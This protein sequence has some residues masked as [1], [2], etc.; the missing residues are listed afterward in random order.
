M[1][2][3]PLFWQTLTLV[4][5]AFLFAGTVKGIV[6]AGLPTFSL[7]ILALGLGLKEGIALIVIPALVTNVW[8]GLVGGQLVALTRRL[9]TFLIATV[10][11]SLGGAII[12]AN[13]DALVLSGVLGI[14][15]FLYSVFSLTTPQIP[16]PGRAEKY[17][18]PIMGGATGVML[19]MIGSFFVPGVLYLQAL[20]LKRDELVQ[21]LG[22]AFTVASLA[23]GV[24][25][26]S[27]GLYSGAY[28]GFSAFAVAPALLGMVA[29]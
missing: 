28:L 6:G 5:V 15:L 11:G 23:L 24:G 13:G 12:L 1:T 19:G 17:L 4:T 27:N 10:I 20:G 26:A 7:P 18:S 14:F 29:G 22:I 2:A 8:Q 21:A 9:G 16:A 3:D 25:L